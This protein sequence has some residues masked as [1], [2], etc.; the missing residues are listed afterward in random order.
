[1]GR[2]G[3]RT[4]FKRLNRFAR[5]YRTRLNKRRVG[6][7]RG[8]SRYANLYRAPYRGG[9]MSAGGKTY[10]FNRQASGVT[11]QNGG[12]LGGL[13]TNDDIFAGTVPSVNWSATALSS[14]AGYGQTFCLSYYATLDN[15]RGV[16]EFNTMFDQ[17]CIKGIS[18]KISFLSPNTVNNIP[19]MEYYCDFDDVTTGLTTAAF[20]EVTRRRKFMFKQDTPTATIKW[21]PRVSVPGFSGAIPTYA[22]VA[23]PGFID[24]N[25]PQVQHYGLK[26][27]FR[28]LNIPNV[29]TVPGWGFTIVPTY[30]LR[31]KG[32][33]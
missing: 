4:A 27:C 26:M 5:R 1:M 21:S 20:S 17:Y 11:I 8:R 16:S 12:P 6:T 18:F 3:L 14:D 29:S 30:H 24:I 9:Y 33:R 28:H 19:T 13:I 7:F 32:V 25:A 31:F 2:L 15:V 10:S 22:K 23:R